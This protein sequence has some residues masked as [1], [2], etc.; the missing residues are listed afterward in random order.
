MIR[1]S[2]QSAYSVHIK[3]H[4]PWAQVVCYKLRDFCILE[5]LNPLP[6][7]LEVDYDSF[8]K[9]KSSQNEAL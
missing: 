8:I 5:T 4:G 7:I 2:R 6:Y 1:R 9:K 3:K